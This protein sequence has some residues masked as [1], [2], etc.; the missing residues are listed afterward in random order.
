MLETGME[1]VSITAG[2]QTHKPKQ[3]S[4]PSVPCDPTELLLAELAE[5]R[6]R[7]RELLQW[8]RTQVASERPP[9]SN[10]SAKSHN[11]RRARPR[12]KGGAGR[13]GS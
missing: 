2:A 3:G 6:A 10:K 9:A 8:I 4:D 12:H 1:S 7:L 13:G 5:R 11:C